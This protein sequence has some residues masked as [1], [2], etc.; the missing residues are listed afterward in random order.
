MAS[1]PQLACL[2]ALLLAGPAAA[3][4]T[5]SLFEEAN[6]YPYVW[7]A[8]LPCPGTTLAPACAETPRPVQVLGAAARRPHPGQ[9]CADLP[10]RQAHQGTPAAAPARCP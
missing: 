9:Q 10:A 6:Y 8:R 2:A 3:V 5:M 4:Y 7:R 1:R